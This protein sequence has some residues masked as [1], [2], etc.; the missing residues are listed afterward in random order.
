MRLTAQ[1]STRKF[2]EVVWPLMATVLRVGRILTGNEAEAEDLAQE[3]MLKAF[4]GIES[5]AEGTNVKAWLL[6]ILRRCRIDRLRS[7]AAGPAHTVSLES[8]EMDPAD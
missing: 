2:H 1:E 3:T 4:V 7:A 8:L 5:F 6:T